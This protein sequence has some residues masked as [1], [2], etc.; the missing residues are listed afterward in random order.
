MKVKTTI[1]DTWSER[2][3]KEWPSPKTP[4]MPLSEKATF[5]PS[6]KLRL[7]LVPWAAITE[8]A[9]VMDFGADKHGRYNW[10]Q[11]GDWSELV[12]AAM[13]HLLAWVEGERVDPETGLSHLSHLACNVL[14]LI[15]CE[16]NGIGVDDIGGKK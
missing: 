15:C 2:L 13:R 11:G 6:R 16:K 12:D 1:G 8:V 14:M 3:G 5:K 9:K 4:P 7:H 10:M